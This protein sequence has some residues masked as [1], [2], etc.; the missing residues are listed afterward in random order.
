MATLETDY[1]TGLKDA[2]QHA[3]KVSRA[4]SA[5]DLTDRRDKWAVGRQDEISRFV[6]LV[7]GDWREGR[8]SEPAAVAELES[9][10]HTLE[11]ALRERL[12]TSRD[13]R[14][15]PVEP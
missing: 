11:N 2:V 14:P 9:Y 8:L 4:L 10:M 3:V 1:P 13:G 5:L 12:E 15:T 6:E 7:L